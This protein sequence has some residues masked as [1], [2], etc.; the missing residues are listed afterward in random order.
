MTA[1]EV[2][3]K[4]GR[5]MTSVTITAERTSIKIPREHPKELRDQIVMF[6]KKIEGEVRQKFNKSMRGSF[7][8][9]FERLELWNNTRTENISFEFS[10]ENC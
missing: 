5:A 2:V 4:D 6:V 8:A 1:F 10:N 3:I 9:G 7:T